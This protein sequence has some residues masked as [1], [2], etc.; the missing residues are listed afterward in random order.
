VWTRE[1]LEKSYGGRGRFC[2]IVSG[3]VDVLKALAKR[4]DEGGWF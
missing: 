1:K 3:A 4:G 2:G